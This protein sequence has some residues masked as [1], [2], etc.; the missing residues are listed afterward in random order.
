PGVPSVVGSDLTVAVEGQGIVTGDKI[1]CG[2]KCIASYGFGTLEHLKAQATA[3]YTFEGWQGGCGNQ[4]D[5]SFPVGP[6]SA[7]KARFAVNTPKP[8]LKASLLSIGSHGK[9]AARR[10]TARVKSSLAATVKL[11]LE[12]VAGKKIATRAVHVGAGQS[13]VSL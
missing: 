5:C 11:R 12:T 7:V 8:T 10:V 3:G 13:T 9:R 6:I 4:S 1:D 2:T